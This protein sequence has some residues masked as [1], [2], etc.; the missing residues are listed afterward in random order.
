MNVTGM[1]SQVSL[2]G[3]GGTGTT[4]FVV[5][6]SGTGTL[7]ITNGGR[8]LINDTSSVA[9]GNLAIGGS[10]ADSGEHADWRG[11][12]DRLRAG[13]SARHPVRPR[14]HPARQSRDGDDERQ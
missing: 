1:G 7:N 12:G 8:V 2:V 6:R 9:D 13:L 11:Y 14:L 4:Q 10:T 5:G 3:S